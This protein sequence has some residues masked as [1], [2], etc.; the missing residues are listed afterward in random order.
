VNFALPAPVTAIVNVVVYDWCVV[1]VPGDVALIVATSV[2]IFWSVLEPVPIVV[3]FVAVNDPTVAVVAPAMPDPAP[4]APISP[5][6]PAR[7]DTPAN[8]ATDLKRRDRID[9]PA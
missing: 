3:G 7:S 9:P 2:P 5:R 1:D 6:P 4:R 8:P